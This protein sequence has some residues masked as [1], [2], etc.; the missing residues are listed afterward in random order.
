MR[1]LAVD[2]DQFIL[3]LIKEMLSFVGYADVTLASGGNQALDIIQSGQAFDCFLLDIRMPDLDGIELCKLIRAKPQYYRVPI[4]MVSAV[5]DEKSFVR[6][7]DDGA[8][9]YIVKPFNP[10][11]LQHR[12]DVAREYAEQRVSGSA[13]ALRA[14]GGRMHTAFRAQVARGRV[15]DM[16][17]KPP[18]TVAEIDFIPSVR[19][20]DDFRKRTLARRARRMSG[21]FYSEQPEKH[22]STVEEIE[23]WRQPTKQPKEPRASSEPEQ[24][25]SRGHRGEY[26]G[27]PVLTVVHSNAQ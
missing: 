17:V 20:L 14:G 2:D 8:T 27:S 23:R 11:D 25:S 18:Q 19:A 15:R 9:D 4:I 3:E 26:R 13:A 12:L 1:I 16:V 7:F 21:V 22:V 5:T 6:A 24:R 10:S